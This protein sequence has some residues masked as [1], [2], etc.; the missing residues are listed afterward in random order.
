[1]K[2]HTAIKR[3]IIWI[4]QAISNVLFCV[5]LGECGKV[6]GV[7]KKPSISLSELGKKNGSEFIKLDH[8]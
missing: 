3:E 4:L 1:M 2:R 7:A 6:R 5:C 8:K